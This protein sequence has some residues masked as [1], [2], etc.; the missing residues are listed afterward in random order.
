[1]AS[2]KVDSEAGHATGLRA[3]SVGKGEGGIMRSPQDRR[4][5]GHMT[6]M[7]V[8]KFYK[9]YVGVR[10]HATLGGGPRLGDHAIRPEHESDRLC[11]RS[12][13][14][15]DWSCDR[16]CLGW[17]GLGWKKGGPVARPAPLRVWPIPRGFGQTKFEGGCEFSPLGII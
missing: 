8:L 5:A 13:I 2:I 11:D 1:M 12:K 15:E 7:S 6:G 4:V 3:T 16:F 9:C 17:W 10:G 14:R